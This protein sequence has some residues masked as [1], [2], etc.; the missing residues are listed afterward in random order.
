MTKERQSNFELMRIISMFFIVIYHIIGHGSLLNNTDGLIYFCLVFIRAICIVHVNSFVILCGYFN[1][2]K[3]FSIKKVISLLNQ[4]LFYGALIAIIFKTTILIELTNVDFLKQF[5]YLP[6]NDYW[7]IKNYIVLYCISPF[8]NITIKNMDKKQ[9]KTLLITLFIFFSIIPIITGNNTFSVNDGFSLY[10]F[11]FMYFLGAYLNIYPIEKSRLFKGLNKEKVKIMLI[12]LFCT[13]VVFNVSLLF[14]GKHLAT[15]NSNIFNEISGYLINCFRCYC[16]PIVIIQT[17]CYFLFFRSLDIKSK[18]I[19]KIGKFTFGVYLIHDNEILRQ[20]LYKWMK[21]DIG[22]MIY[23]KRILIKIFVCAIIIYFICTII[24][25]IRYNLFRFISKLK[26]SK[27]ISNK[28]DNFI[29]NFS[30]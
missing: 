19:N 14:L 20:L 4:V 2:K 16:N 10:Q 24:E 11:V 28:F 13:L 3:E 12:S 23:S 21:I 29:S 15:F 22:T 27:K 5:S 30:Q 9:F 6:F 7:F 25:A 17:I 8:L 26:V 1:Y 18:L